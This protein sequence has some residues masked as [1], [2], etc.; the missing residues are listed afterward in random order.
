MVNVTGEGLYKGVEGRPSSFTIEGK[1]NSSQ[2]AVQVDGPNS[3]AK[4]HV[5]PESDDTYKVTYVPVEVGQY[6]VVIKWNGQNV[7]GGPWRPE[8][9]SPSKVAVIGGWQSHMDSKSR[10]ALVVNEM[11][12]IEFDTSIAG[13]GN[14]TGE[15][16]GPTGSIPVENRSIG[17][18]RYLLAFT[19]QVAGEHYV[20]VSW[21]GVELPDSPLAG[22]AMPER[23][24]SADGVEK[25]V[26]TGS[27]LQ[28][29]RVKEEG[30][31]VIDG[32][33]AG[34]GSPDVKIVGLKSHVNVAITPLG[35]DK[36]RCTYI[37]EQPGA[38]L[39]NVKWG[40]RDVKG[41]PFKISVAA[42]AD[43]NK[44]FCSSETLRTAIYGKDISTTIDTRRA[45]PGELQAQCNG[46]TKVAFCELIDEQNG[47]FKLKIKPQETGKHI[48]QIKYAG[49]HIPGSPFE[50]KVQGAPD[51]TKIRVTGPGIEHGILATFKSRFVV[52]TKGAGAGQLTVRVRGPKAAFRVEMKKESQMDRTILCRYDPTE[53][54]DYTI[55][56]KWSGSNVP[57]SPFLV[58]IFDSH[59]EL[60]KYK[61]GAS[62]GIGNTG[63]VSRS[64]WMADM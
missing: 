60:E 20:S 5:E 45:G 46:P 51:P 9:I 35:D 25:V 16:R 62:N 14:L 32:S 59:D 29:A 48:L 55:A 1:G 4:C 40:D 64:N 21:G 39:L 27:G 50:V 8:I 23:H 41:S 37:P 24:L 2:L 12:R 44:V 3:V 49:Q 13:N 36:F 30:E 34:P 53:V 42:Q 61:F 56:I 52:E 19:P 28:T 38:Y 54:G 26:L 63:T 11:K 6:F 18:N 47:T 57:G 43:P 31:F 10:I 7:A 15:V 58:K 33:L 22:Y 17:S